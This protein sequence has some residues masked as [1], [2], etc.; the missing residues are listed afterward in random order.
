MKK[1]ILTFFLI[2]LIVLLVKRT[3][4]FSSIRGCKVSCGAKPTEKDFYQCLLNDISN[5]NTLLQKKY[6]HTQ[7]QIV[8]RLGDRIKNYFISLYIHGLEKDY[9][10]VVAFVP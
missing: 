9:R 1:L 5:Y 6:T 10:F 7:A 8:S 3:E 4:N 2:I